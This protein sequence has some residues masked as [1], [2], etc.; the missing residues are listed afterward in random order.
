[1]LVIQEETVL[2]LQLLPY[3]H[4]IIPIA[5]YSLNSLS[6]HIMKFNKETVFLDTSNALPPPIFI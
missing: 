5:I 3:Y 4:Q 6:F 1:M 2:T